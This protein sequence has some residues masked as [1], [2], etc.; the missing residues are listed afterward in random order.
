MDHVVAT[1][2]RER[3]QPLDDGLLQ[4]GADDGLDG[5]A[6]EVRKPLAVATEN[7]LAL[8]VDV[9]SHRQR[10]ARARGG[11]E[12]Q[13]LAEADVQ[14]AAAPQLDAFGEAREVGAGLRHAVRGQRVA[15]VV[16]PVLPEVELPGRR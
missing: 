14:E 6:G 3:R 11:E 13:A 7:L 5:C 2:P 8:R 9:A 10:G 15:G 16:V 4:D 1:G 12:A